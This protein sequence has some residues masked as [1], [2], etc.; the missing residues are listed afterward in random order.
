MKKRIFFGIIV[1]VFFLFLVLRNINIKNTLER[2]THGI[3]W[4]LFPVVVSYTLAF[5]FRAVRWKYLLLPIKKFHWRQLFSSLVMGFA[6]NCV[7]PFRFGELV[8]AYIVGK[9]HCI[10]KSSSLATIVLER[11]VDGVAVLI[12]LGFAVPFLPV[13]PEWAKQAIFIA[14]IL[15]I[16]ALIAFTI[17][18]IKKQSMDWL[19][20]IPLLKVEL[21][22]K[23][24]EN[25]KTFI[26]GFEVIKD[27]KN[28]FMVIVFSVCVWIFETFNMFFLVKIVGI[29][30]P[31][32]AIIFIL[33]ATILGITIPAA[34]GSIG[35]FEAAFVVGLMFFKIP[36]ESAV[37]SA[38]ITHFVGIAYV[39]IL[40]TY[41]FFR[42]GVSYKEIS[43]TE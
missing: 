20:K 28:F 13:F 42:E 27:R 2:I 43:K 8:R 23:L 32:A 12:L 16:G 30:L 34:P 25:I 24:V 17:L 39:M 9:K 1:S 31:F 38:L 22:E 3:Y 6:A 18:I 37:A 33:F 36:K 29:N 19:K 14:I 15:F 5:L 26:V 40:G 4:W 11:I 7:F 35:T 41:F 21:K 10:P